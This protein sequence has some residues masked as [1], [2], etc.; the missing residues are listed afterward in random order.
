MCEQRFGQI[1]KSVILCFLDNH[2]ANFDCD[3]FTPDATFGDFDWPIP[4]HSEGKGRDRIQ[5][6]C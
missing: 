1:G 3:R 2:V 4:G 5:Y 6:S